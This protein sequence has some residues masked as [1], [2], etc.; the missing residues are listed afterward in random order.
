MTTLVICL[1]VFL[2]EKNS[3]NASYAVGYVLSVVGVI[4]FLN[5]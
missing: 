5:Q 1:Y 3:Q 4:Y 2:I